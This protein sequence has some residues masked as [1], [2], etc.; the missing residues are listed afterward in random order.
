MAGLA[1]KFITTTKHLRSSYIYM[2]FAVTGLSLSEAE[3]GV[4][5]N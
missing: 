5:Y 3:P 2:S 4:Y 1:S